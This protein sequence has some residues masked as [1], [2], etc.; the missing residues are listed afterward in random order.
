MEGCDAFYIWERC[1]DWFENVMGQY[2]LIF[3]V[4]SAANVN[5]LPNDKIKKN[6]FVL[7]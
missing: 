3:L 5:I 7:R 4:L 6:A 2:T 1:A